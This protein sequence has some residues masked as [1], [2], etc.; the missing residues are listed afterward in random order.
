MLFA[1][2]KRLDHFINAKEAPFLSLADI[3]FES[4][5][6]PFPGKSVPKKIL[7]HYK[8]QRDFPALDATS[9]LGVHLRF[10]TVSVRDLA[11]K[12]IEL[13]AEVWLSELI[14]REFFMQIMWHNPR[15]AKEPFKEKYGKIK[16]RHSPQDFKAWSQGRTGYTLVD[17]GMR[18][19]NETGHMH[20][21]VRM[22]TASFLVKHLLINWQEGER[23]FAEKLFDF[24]LASNNG[25]WQWVAGCGCDA[26]P[27]FRIFNPDTQQE[28][29]DKDYK[30]VQKWVP[31][32][33]TTHYTPKIVDHVVARNRA[34]DA[35][36][37]L[38]S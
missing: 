8:T 4:A 21:R 33:K 11:R 30:Y 23:Y 10:G 27:Y 13:K 19:L 2:E 37:V 5:D 31:E 14:W 29:F 34:L 17:A 9:H 24:D 35:F 1:T 26:A 12:A 25:N 36:K 15:V 18:E 6:I 38:K 3:G 22:V 32:Y 20:N 7:T 28:K 16:W